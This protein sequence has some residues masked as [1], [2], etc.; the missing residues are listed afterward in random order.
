MK[1]NREMNKKKHT[2][3]LSLRYFKDCSGNTE[4]L[5]C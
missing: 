1:S 3:V 4:I 5:H 2:S